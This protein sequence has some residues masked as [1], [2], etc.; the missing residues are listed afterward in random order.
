MKISKTM[1][2]DPK[3]VVAVEDL[4]GKGK[5]A[6]FSFIAQQGLEEMVKFYNSN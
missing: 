6:S 4:I 3:L 1:S 2:I 5:V